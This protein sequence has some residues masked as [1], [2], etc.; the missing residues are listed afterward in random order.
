MENR[1]KALVNNLSN[2]SVYNHFQNS[3]IAPPNTPV[4]LQ[5]AM[6]AIL[7]KKPAVISAY[8]AEARTNQRQSSIQTM[9]KGRFMNDRISSPLS[10]EKDVLAKIDEKDSKLPT[11]M[12]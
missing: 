7:Q 1:Y 3:N 11:K 10:D 4:L 8:L 6:P 12:S 9:V 5:L 2:G